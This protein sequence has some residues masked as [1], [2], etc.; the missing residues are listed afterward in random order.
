M[1]T[2][3]IIIAAVLVMVGMSVMGQ[4][5]DSGDFSTT[6][7]RIVIGSTTDNPL[8]NLSTTGKSIFNGTMD[9]D[10]LKAQRTDGVFKFGWG[11][12]NGADA[13]MNSN[14]H[15]TEPGVFKILYGGASSIG[16][17]N[18]INFNGSA[19]ITNFHI[20]YDGNVGIGTT[21]PS[22]KLEVNG[23][24]K[25]HNLSAQGKITTQ[26]VEVTLDGWSDYVFEEDYNLMP[27]SEVEKFV[28]KNKHLPG[29]PSEKEIIEE[30]L[31]LGE[32]NR[33]LME[34]VEELTLHVIEL[35]KKINSNTSNQ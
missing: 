16:A 1:K 17:F 30:G 34:K 25:A 29:I 13:V 10:R 14:T 27:L 7:D 9:V 24:I 3:K 35:E 11:A 5:V 18:I 32:M 28:K 23:D 20:G 26:E 21:S 19:Y 12:I 8:Y 6:L 31:S 33:L 15:A 4:W 22:E 2:I